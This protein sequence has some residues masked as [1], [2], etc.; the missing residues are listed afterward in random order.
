MIQYQNE[1]YSGEYVF[2][3]RSHTDWFVDTHLHEF[4]ELIYCKEGSGSVT[5]NG[6][7]FTLFPGYLVWLPPNYVHK[8]D[9]KNSEVVCAVFSNDFIPLYGITAGE[10]KLVSEPVFMEELCAV[11]NTLPLQDSDNRMQIC[12][13]LHLICAKVLGHSDFAPE[14]AAESI[15]YQKV[16]SY[17]STHFT[18]DITLEK[19]ATK[20]G[21]NPKYL[22]HALHTLTAVNFRELLAHYRISHAKELLLSRR[23]MSIS[24]V[25]LDCGFTAQ[26]TFNRT[27]KKIVGL[28]P[29]AYR[30]ASH[31]R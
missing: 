9:F 25:A 7:T 4:S 18:E 1:N 14:N 11:L 24:E 27:F 3:C 22:S 13:L 5:V 26:N 2:R 12:G 15:L 17:I 23:D 30:N 31:H 19:T 6:N 8:Y 21:Y 10:R 28:T 20:F 16:I 29:F